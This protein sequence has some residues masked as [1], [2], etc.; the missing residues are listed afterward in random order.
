MP[1][2]PNGHGLKEGR[3]CLE[4][5]GE[6]LAAPPSGDGLRIRS[7]EAHANV[8]VVVPGGPVAVAAPTL[9]KCPKCGRCSAETDTFDCTGPCGRANLCLRHFDE[10][11]DLCKDCA[12][13]KRGLAQQEAARRA[14]LHSDLENLAAQVQRLT[15][16][17]AQMTQAREAAQSELAHAHASLR[18]AEEA[19]KAV[20]LAGQ[21]DL[22][23][24]QKML[25]EWRARAEKVETGLALTTQERDARQADLAQ[26]Q[27]KLV[28]AQAAAERAAVEWQTKLAALERSLIEWRGR[29]EKAEGRLAEIDRKEREAE[30]ARQAE[31]RRQREEAEAAARRAA[32]AASQHPVWQRIGIELITIPAGEFLYGENKQKVSLPAY[33]IAVTPVTNAQYKAFVDATGYSAPSHWSGGRIPQG[34]ENHPVVN[35]DWNDAGNFCAWA[36][37]R[38]PSEQ[39]WEKAARGTDGREYPW[40]AWQHGRCNSSEAKIGATTPVDR[41]PSGASPYGVLDA[42]GNVWEWCA[43][44]YDNNKDARV[45][46]G[47][48]FDLV[49]QGVRCA[50]RYG[51]GPE[52]RY[53]RLG[54]RVASP[55]L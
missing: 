49:S 28:A 6:L 29:G 41:F 42:A 48:S 40:G 30:A 47:G 50:I 9:V 37:G 38:L 21:A 43:D 26:A 14:K 22:S 20:A 35:V 17:L 12:A 2:C 8:Q 54:F 53:G 25:A 46:R 4:C 55:G 45:L 18:Q 7:P 31:L 3:Y 1:Y 52:H 24:T 13:E 36:G 19:A 32:E 15:A 5:G 23:S 34:Q 39:E 44:D 10:E 27:E 11:Y 33:R 51:S 16:E